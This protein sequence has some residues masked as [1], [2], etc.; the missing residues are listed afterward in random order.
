METEQQIE[1]RF[2]AS[3][4]VVALEKMLQGLSELEQIG[5]H[6]Y[7]ATHPEVLMA[8]LTFSKEI[9]LRKYALT[10]DP[11]TDHDIDDFVEFIVGVE[12]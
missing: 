1:Q 7:V 5:L 11:I 6:A 3:E 9:V 4:A 10:D 2:I 8:A 12:K